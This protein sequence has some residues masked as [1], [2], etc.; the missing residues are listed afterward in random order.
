MKLFRKK[1]Q[2]NKDN[3]FDKSVLIRYLNA[4]SMDDQ[5]IAK[6]SAEK[7]NID[8]ENLPILEE[9]CAKAIH[10]EIDNFRCF[11]I[12]QEIKNII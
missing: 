1:N 8:Y 9:K 7:Y 11:Q 10:K 4:R 3:I 6:E 12:R 2:N 5:T